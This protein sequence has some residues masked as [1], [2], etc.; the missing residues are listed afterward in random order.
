[1]PDGQF[2][3]FHFKTSFAMLQIN[4]C[5]TAFRCIIFVEIKQ[6]LLPVSDPSIS[7][8]RCGIGASDALPAM[9]IL[10]C[11]AQGGNR[12][13]RAYWIA[14]SATPAEIAAGAP[15][16]PTDP[17]AGKLETDSV[18]GIISSNINGVQHEIKQSAGNLF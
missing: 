13:G 2:F 8:F 3:F 4:S 15:G 6:F 16:Q 12:S 17:I 11:P 1:L 18:G 9:I 10:F 5:A 14:L 7:S